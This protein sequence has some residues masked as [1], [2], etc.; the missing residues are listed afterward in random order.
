MTCDIVNYARSQG[1]WVIVTDNQPTEKSAA[2]Q[3]ADE[4]WPVSTA[5][6]D[7]LEKLA[8]Q[9]QVNGIFA[10][11]SEF[12]LEKALTL[13]ERLGLP[14]YCTRKQW[15][16]CSNKKLFKQLCIANDI[17]VPGEYH[18]DINYNPEDLRRIKYPVIV[19]PVDRSAGTGISICRNEDELRKA[20]TRAS[21]LSKLKQVIVEEFIHGD[22]IIV[23]YIIKDGQF[24][25][26]SIGDRYF[27]PEPGETIRLP[28]VHMLPSKYT[29]RYIAEL[30]DKVLKM[31]RSIGLANGFIFL[32]GIINNTGF[33]IHETNYR[34]GGALYYRFSGNIYGINC[35][36]MLVNYALS[37]KMGGGDISLENPI[38]SKFCCVLIMLSK[39]GVWW[40]K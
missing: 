33:H 21:S 31:F 35:M 5:D 27:Y 38:F 36:E 34:L 10:G 29:H 20:Y 18:I 32:Q 2:K 23:V 26:S 22:E 3:I 25:L 12:N 9:N 24:S 7:T 6:V 39:G 4:A 15:E 28:Q 37:G 30:N 14:F 8:I 19:K 16:T 13:C 17:P 40:V 1:A 11:V